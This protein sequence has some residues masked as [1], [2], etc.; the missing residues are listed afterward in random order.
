MPSNPPS[1]TT[2]PRTPTL[3]KLISAAQVPACQKLMSRLW[4]SPRVGTLQL[5]EFGLMAL[6]YWVYN[7]DKTTFKCLAWMH[8]NF[9]PKLGSGGEPAALAIAIT[10]SFNA[11]WRDEMYAILWD[12]PMGTRFVHVYCTNFPRLRFHLGA[13]RT[14]KYKRSQI[15]TFY[16]FT[17]FC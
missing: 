3:V 9:T 5:R 4:W 15:K 17:D 1:P 13:I 2:I 11:T 16:I 12:F 6:G 8:G 10:G 14:F 7:S